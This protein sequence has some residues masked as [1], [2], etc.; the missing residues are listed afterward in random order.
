MIE[1]HVANQYSV[2]VG[3][4]FLLAYRTIHMFKLSARSYAEIHE[5]GCSG[6][7]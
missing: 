4:V 3:A 1:N 6:Y 5:D 2:F 7:H